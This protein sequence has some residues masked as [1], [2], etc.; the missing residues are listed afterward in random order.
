MD[1]LAVDDDVPGLIEGDGIDVKGAFEQVVLVDF[2]IFFV[3]AGGVVRNG[4]LAVVA[5]KH[6]K[7]GECGKGH[8]K[9]MFFIK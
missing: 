3:R 8:A 5:C 7:S 2:D 1:G 6:G 9:G 4:V